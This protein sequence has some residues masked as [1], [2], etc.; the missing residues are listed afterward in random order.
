MMHLDPTIARLVLSNGHVSPATIKSTAAATA[1]L[2]ALGNGA[3]ADPSA[4]IVAIDTAAGWTSQGPGTARVAVSPD[5]KTRLFIAVREDKLKCIMHTPT[6]LALPT[7]T[8]KFEDPDLDKHMADTLPLPANPRVDKRAAN[9]YA[10]FVKAATAGMRDGTDPVLV[11]FEEVKG[12]GAIEDAQSVVTF[13]GYG[14]SGVLA[15]VAGLHAAVRNA[16]GG[17]VGFTT[18]V[19]TFGSQ[20]PGN[21]DF[22]TLVRSYSHLF[23]HRVARTG[24][25]V[26]NWPPTQMGFSHTGWE[27]ALEPASGDLTY[28]VEGTT[29]MHTG[30]DLWMAS[31]CAGFACLIAV[32]STIW[33]GVWHWREAKLPATATLDHGAGFAWL[34]VVNLLV[35]GLC[36]YIIWGGA[37]GLSSAW[38][39][40]SVNEE[41]PD[42]GMPRGVL[43]RRVWP[44]NRVAAILAVVIALAVVVMSQTAVHKVHAAKPSAVAGGVYALLLVVVAGAVLG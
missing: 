33:G 18:R 39:A 19:L 22:D 27:V 34:L 44:G 14:S 35:A 9:T 15:V 25:L 21:K 36:A 20:R 30:M 23:V 40:D 26:A 41:S 3:V 37:H 11:A 12:D 24:D 10:A 5:G 1:A 13:A 7:R 16:S 29:A 43:C 42:P 38:Y 31:L 4:A 2:A 8:I 28:C 17:F 32:A 6:A